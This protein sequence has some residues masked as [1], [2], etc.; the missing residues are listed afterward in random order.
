MMCFQLSCCFAQAL[1]Q[2]WTGIIS[3]YTLKTMTTDSSEFALDSNS[4]FDKSKNMSQ[5]VEIVSVDRVSPEVNG[6]V[7]VA[8][9]ENVNVPTA[10]KQTA[11][12]V[13]LDD[14]DNRKCCSLQ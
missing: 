13:Q 10:E 14:A 3:Y 1:W 6:G 8:L 11:E 5:E 7:S 9:V 2:L 4:G 12:R